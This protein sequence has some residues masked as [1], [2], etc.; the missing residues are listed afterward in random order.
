MTVSEVCQPDV[1]SAITSGMR[2]DPGLDLD[3]IAA[4]LN[5]QYDLRVSAITFLP[6]GYDLNAAVYEVI[7]KDRTDYFLKIRFS[8]VNESDSCPRGFVRAR[9]PECACSAANAI[10]CALVL[11]RWTQSGSLPVY[12]RRGRDDQRDHR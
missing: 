6:L 1:A 4:C 9:D 10:I 8:P 11:L 7:A 2:D 5:A 12:R 3:A